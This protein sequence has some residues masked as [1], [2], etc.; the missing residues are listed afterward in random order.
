MKGS[1]SIRKQLLGWLMIPIVS[2]CLVSAVGTYFIAVQ[3]TTQ[4]YDAALME[5]ARELANR[6]SVAN[7]QVSIDLPPAAL[8]VFREDNIDKFY[9][10]VIENGGRVVDGDLAFIQAIQQHPLRKGRFQNR[11]V[12]KSTVRSAFIESV[13]P[14]FPAK[15]VDVYVAET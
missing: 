5:S 1:S 2:L 8:A 14:G 10:A 4:A 11:K 13:L 12:L 3:I 6:L 15:K 9:Y 7:G